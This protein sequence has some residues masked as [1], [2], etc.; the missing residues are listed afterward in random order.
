MPEPG[1]HRYDVERT[2]LR[3]QYDNSGVP[4][5]HAD[6]AANAELQRDNPPV[7]LGD[8]ARAAGPTGRGGDSRGDPGLDDPQ[9]APSGVVLRS[10]AFSDH[11]LIPEQYAQAG[12]DIPPPLEWAQVPDGVA[13]FALYCED[14]DAND[15]VHWVVTGIPASTSGLGEDRLPDGA[16]PGRNDD[17]G[18]GWSGP[19]PPIGDDPHRYRFRLL[20]LDQPLH[21]GEDATVADVHAAAGGHEF[22]RGTLVG[23][24]GR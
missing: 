11:T 19:H 24:F 22:A 17:G 16:I 2:R 10:T 12:G 4:D 14:I 7:P 21:L 18:L 13:E 8:P 5:Q 20:V 6:D 1:S 9:A 23:R 3:A 15:F